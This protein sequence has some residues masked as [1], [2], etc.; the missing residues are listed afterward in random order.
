MNF[1]KMKL[2]TQLLFIMGF[3]KINGVSI[4]YLC[5]LGV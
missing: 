5:A 4:G 3:Q 2:G 1:S